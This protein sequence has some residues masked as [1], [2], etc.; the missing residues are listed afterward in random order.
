MAC[1]F[2]EGGGK[3][4]V[5]YQ[6]RDSNLQTADAVSTCFCTPC[7]CLYAPPLSEFSLQGGKVGAHQQVSTMTEHLI[8]TGLSVRVCTDGKR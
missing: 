5:F 7:V 1:N 2:Q 3:V 6:N 4:L 8:D